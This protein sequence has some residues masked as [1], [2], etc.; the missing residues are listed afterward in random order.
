M[1][2]RGRGCYE[3]GISFTKWSER[4]IV[5][6]GEAVAP[7]LR[8]VWERISGGKNNRLLSVMQNINSKIFLIRKAIVA[9]AAIAFILSGLFPPWLQTL[10]V[11]ATHNHTDAGYSFILSPPLPKKGAYYS[12][13][14]GI[15]LDTTRLLI[16][17]SCILVAAGSVWFLCGASKSKENEQKAP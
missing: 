6:N 2:A 7:H 8:E 11:T 3:K 4:M 16:E 13:D 14:Y 10:D 1:I 17:W 9:V 12:E 5:C 15:Q